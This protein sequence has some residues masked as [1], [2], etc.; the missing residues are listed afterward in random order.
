MKMDEEKK[1]QE[2]A[3]IPLSKEEKEKALG[4]AVVLLSGLVA[5]IVYLSLRNTYSALSPEDTYKYFVQ[6]NIEF[7][8]SASLYAYGEDYL[9]SK[10]N[11]WE[12]FDKKYFKKGDMLL[13]IRGCKKR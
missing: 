9:V 7:I 4:G 3:E 8:C 1:L 10:K 12:L 13:D 5:L 6:K 11:G 2:E